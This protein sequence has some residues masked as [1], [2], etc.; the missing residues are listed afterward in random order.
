MV[1][2]KNSRKKWSLFTYVI[3]VSAVS[4]GCNSIQL[5]NALWVSRHGYQGFAIIDNGFKAKMTKPVM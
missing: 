4:Y 3:L 1:N 2:E 5:S